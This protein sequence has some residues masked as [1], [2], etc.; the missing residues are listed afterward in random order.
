[1]N[2][3]LLFLILIILISCQGKETFKLKGPTGGDFS[4]PTTKGVFKTQDHRNK[5]LFVFFGFTHCPQ[6]C[7]KTLSSLHRMT[8]LL[9]DKEKDKVEI[10]FITVDSKRDTMD[11]LK[12]RM[13]DYSDSF[14]GA[15]DSEENLK[16]IMAQFGASYT[17]YGSKNPDDMIIDHTTDIFLINEK[18]EWV[19]SL[20][21]DS[22]PEEL[23]ANFKSVNKMSPV[24]AKHRQNR[25]IDVLAEN[26][27]CDLG[28]NPCRL[29]NYEISL[30]PLPVTA[31]KDFTVTVKT[32]SSQ[33]FIP[34]EVDLEG[35]EQNMGYMRPKLAS[36]GFQTFT[37]HF[38]IPSCDLPD[39]HWQARLI[40]GTPEGPKSLNFYFKSGLTSP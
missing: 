14:Y 31:E 22:T 19:R 30:S 34:I 2:K 5:V 40:L 4:I 16:K 8:K 10:L 32:L 36:T 39:M 15:V 27:E 20:K 24:Y 1:M 21:Y 6:V 33:A 25:T 12:K 9:A 17:I 18:G 7:P 38:Y 26:R 37:G 35:V 13:K 11:V 29:N 3:C 23:L 28:K